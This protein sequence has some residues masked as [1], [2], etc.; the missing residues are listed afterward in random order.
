MQLLSS[1]ASSSRLSSMFFSEPWLATQSKAEV[2]AGHEEQ[3]A[4]SAYKL[5][6]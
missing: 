3:H 5:L 2:Q 4:S 1:P 6:N